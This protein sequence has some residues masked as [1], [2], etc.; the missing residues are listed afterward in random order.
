ME[1]LKAWGHTIKPISWWVNIK[2]HNK[3]EVNTVWAVA[4]PRKHIHII[5]KVYSFIIDLL[6]QNSLS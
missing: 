6:Q 5:E 4:E 1:K 2:I 3:K